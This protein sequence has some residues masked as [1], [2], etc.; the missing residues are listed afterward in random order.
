[1]SVWRG[2]WR[3][4]AFPSSRPV[5]LAIIPRPRS[6]SR[7]ESLP[8]TV[9]HFCRAFRPSRVGCIARRAMI[10][11]GGR[12]VA[13]SGSSRRVRTV[14]PTPRATR[15]PSLDLH[16]ATNFFTCLFFF[17]FFVPVHAKC[18]PVWIAPNAAKVARPKSLRGMRSDFSLF[19]GTGRN[20]WNRKNTESRG[21]TT[22]ERTNGSAA[23]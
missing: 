14:A 10:L 13:S 2:G 3:R 5:P 21:K 22:K 16:A 11:P 8:H 17:C 4:S 1:M 19:D 23:R 6:R 9:I 15:T 7:Y 18:G 20:P 12:E